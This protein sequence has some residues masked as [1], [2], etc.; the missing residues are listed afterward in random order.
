MNGKIRLI[1]GVD[2]IVDTNKIKTIE[3]TS[4]RIV[5]K[6]D[7]ESKNTYRFGNGQILLM[8]PNTNQLDRRYTQP[9][10]GIVVSAEDIPVGAEVLLEHNSCHP[11]NE[12]VELKDDN[13]DIKYYSVPELEVYVW[14]FIENVRYPKE[15]LR[16]MASQSF[17][18]W[19]PTKYYAIAERVYEP[20]TGV[21][22][23]I[24]PSVI[25]NTL[26]IKTGELKGKIVH[27]VKNGQYEII[28]QDTNGQ[29]NETLVTFHV[30]NE[31]EL[32]DLILNAKQEVTAINHALTERYLNGELLTGLTPDNCKPLQIETY[33]D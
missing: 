7:T 13:P 22:H 30:E 33:A 28:Y 32:S 6:V 9:V 5:V 8:F 21:F 24:K 26:L 11:T 10:N 1:K 25:K 17:K 14:R 27:T 2:T 29:P 12:I 3:H 31:D 16:E 18:S 15:W 23:G 20:Y 19:H 4:K